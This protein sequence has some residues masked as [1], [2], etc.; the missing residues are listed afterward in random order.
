MTAQVD[1][2]Y[3]EVAPPASVAERMLVMARDRIYRDLI[4][5]MRP[6][7]ACRILDVGVSDVLT[8]GANVLERS[9]RFPRKITACGLGGCVEF[10]HRY[11]DVDYRQIEANKP[12]PFADRSFDIATSNAVLEH[13]GS[14]ENQKFFISEL[15]RVANRVFI[16][17]PNRYFPIEHHTA[18]PFMHYTDRGFRIACSTL[19]K[20]SWAD[21]QNLILLTRKKLW[22]LVADMPRSVTV[23]YTGLRMGPFSSNLYL[24]IR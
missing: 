23:G 3:Y 20:S 5:R 21:E 7:P 16:S 14:H 17:V 18:V 15:A 9:Y 13:V 22:R 8:D 19:R 12:L 6:T 1:A 24:T 4:D 11:P 2:K 10:R